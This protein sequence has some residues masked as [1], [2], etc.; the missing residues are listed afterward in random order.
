MKSPLSEE[1]Q[2]PR[3]H[4]AKMNA[5]KMS[6]KSREKGMHPSAR[7]DRLARAFWFQY[8]VSPFGITIRK[9]ARVKQEDGEHK[10][11]LQT[12]R[13]TVCGFAKFLPNP[14]VCKSSTVSSPLLWLMPF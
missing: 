12:S 10:N 1:M 14:A 7:F 13:Q 9:F 11:P 8:P 3:E 6:W 4:R 5:G 2:Y